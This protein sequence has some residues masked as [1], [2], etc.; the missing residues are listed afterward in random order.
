MYNLPENLRVECRQFLDEMETLP[1]DSAAD[2]GSEL[3]ARMNA[4]AQGH[5]RTCKNCEEALENL[6]ATRNL[7][8]PMVAAMPEAGPWFATRVMAG[9]RAKERELEERREG[10]WHSVRRKAPRLAA[11]CGLLLVFA[12]GWAMHVRSVELARGPE[13]APAETVFGT[14]QNSP[15]N[16]DVLLPVRGIKR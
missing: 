11:L 9:I 16:D 13:M 2:A 5:A 4:A 1:V 3:V 15:F 10:V 6:A 7:L 12:V 8:R 14:A